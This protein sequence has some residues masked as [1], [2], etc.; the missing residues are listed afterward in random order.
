MVSIKHSIC[1]TIF[2]LL[3]D[4]KILK[5]QTNYSLF[6]FWL[7]VFSLIL[8][9]FLYTEL[10]K[11]EYIATISYDSYG[12]YLYLPAFFIYNDPL[13]L[14]FINSITTEYPFLTNYFYQ[15]R[16]TEGGTY[17][18]NYTSGLSILY[19]PAFIIS[20]VFAKLSSFPADGFS[21]PYQIGIHWNGILWAI[22][23]AYFLRKILLYFFSDCASSL[24][25]FIFLFGTNYFYYTAVN[26]SMQHNY[27]FTLYTILIWSCIKWHQ[28]QKLKYSIIIGISIG[29]AVL[30]RPTEI[31]ILVLPLLW[32][33]IDKQTFYEKINL[34]YK[35]KFQLFTIA[36][37][38]LL[39]GSIQL[40]YWKFAV[41]KWLFYSY[42]KDL[43]FNFKNPEILN[44]LFSVKKGWFIHS[45]LMFLSIPALIVSAKHKTPF[46]IGTI[47]YLALH[48]YITFSW[49]VWWY[50]GSFGSRPMIH[51]Y[52]VLAL[53]LGVLFTIVLKLKFKKLFLFSLTPLV[54]ALVS[55]NIFQA[56]QFSNK[57]FSSE[58]ISAYVLKLTFLKTS[59]TQETIY[60]YQGIKKMSNSEKY[61]WDIIVE[62]DFDDDNIFPTDSNI[63][64]SFPNSL[65]IGNFLPPS[66]LYQKS[67][68]ESTTIINISFMGYFEKYIYAENQFAKLYI[69]FYRNKKIIETRKTTLHNITGN[70]N[71]NIE[72]D[73]FGK[74]NI[75][76]YINLS[77]NVPIGTDSVVIFFEGTGC[78]KYYIDNLKIKM[79]N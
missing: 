65:I 62:N 30:M 50:G 52:P 76:D 70:K 59:I 36:I 74:P 13:E 49:S 47:I 40:I 18:M 46:F 68:D 38:I 41:N 11:Q 42:H 33:V 71:I 12:Y 48:I 64:Y 15:A 72:T 43:G 4:F 78:E 27:I 26:N 5:P 16:L 6:I 60:K 37:L 69:D 23:G 9:S 54:F 34:L 39:I 77:Y 35:C 58:G 45:P 51:A 3:N 75:W 8:C 28:K 61:I 31:I 66:T 7:F 79:G 63:F 32:G 53:T 67:I 2:G 73:Y 19:M 57:I 29:L 20:H 25:L 55:I 56:W 22:V 1:N 17:V 10:E 24:V 44:G 21:L 14:N